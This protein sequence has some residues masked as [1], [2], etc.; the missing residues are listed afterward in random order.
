MRDAA[1]LLD[2]CSWMRLLKG[3]Q[4]DTPHADKTKRV[5]KTKRAVQALSHRSQ[6][7]A[8]YLEPETTFSQAKE[9]KTSKRQ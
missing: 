6:S 7:A 3:G 8:L 9:G 1:V 5:S 4:K 2:V